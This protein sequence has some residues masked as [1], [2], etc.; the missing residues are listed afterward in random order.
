MGAS[1]FS[2]FRIAACGLLFLPSTSFARTPTPTFGNTPTR[3]RTQTLT[4][5]S[6]RPRPAAVVQV[7]PNP[8]VSGTTVSLDA[9]ESIYELLRVVRASLR[10]CSQRFV[11]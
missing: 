9:R 7:H 3:T 5:T 8:A 2:S 10:G 11:E 4:P 6:N 1:I